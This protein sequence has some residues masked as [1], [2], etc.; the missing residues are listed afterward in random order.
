MSRY[1]LALDQGTTSSRA[2]VFDR[3]GRAIAAAQ[4]EFPQIFP[5]PGHVEHDPEAIWTSQLAT[6]REALGRAGA[7]AADIAAIGVTNQRETT[8]LWDKATGAP[9]AN[10]IVWQSRITADACAALRDAGHEER[11]RSLTG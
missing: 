10:A 7:T 2:I 9:V 11:V 8:V 3:G 4:Q 6:A 1:V 5:Q